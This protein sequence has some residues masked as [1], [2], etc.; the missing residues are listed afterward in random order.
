MLAC[1]KL[2]APA[3][4]TLPSRGLDFSKTQP[5]FHRSQSETLRS[6]AKTSQSPLHFLDSS[7]LRATSCEQTQGIV[8]ERSR[9]NDT[10]ETWAG[11]MEIK[12]DETGG[13]DG[14]IYPRERKSCSSMILENLYLCSR[15]FTV[16][17]LPASKDDGVILYWGVWCGNF[18]LREEEWAEEKQLAFVASRPRV[19]AFLG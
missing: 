5:P 10:L 13:R 2:C 4:F 7:F 3:K 17:A 19:L 11:R 16:I 14:R 15:P 9:D 12:E 6:E 18:F 1:T 8:R